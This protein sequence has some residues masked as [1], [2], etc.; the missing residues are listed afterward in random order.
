[1]YDNRTESMRTINLL[2][3]MNIYQEVF[4]SVLYRALPMQV[5]RAHGPSC[6]WRRAQESVALVFT[7]WV[8]CEV[9]PDCQPH[10]NYLHE[11]CEL[12]SL[13]V[14]R[15]I[16]CVGGC[17]LAY[18]IHVRAGSDTCF[19]VGMCQLSSLTSKGNIGRLASRS[20]CFS[21]DQGE[22]GHSRL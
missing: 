9:T 1:M 12:G 15:K 11:G 22:T 3:R 19:R 8:W 6:A 4:L 7:R 2:Q 17:F 13:F 21:R 16:F 10:P 14:F 5:R 18:N 20:D